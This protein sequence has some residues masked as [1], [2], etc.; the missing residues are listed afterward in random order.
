MILRQTAG[1]GPSTFTYDNLGRLTT[2]TFG[3]SPGARTQS[4]AYNS[5][6]YLQTVTDTL[7]PLSATTTT[8]SGECST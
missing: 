6:G 4:V 2:S 1:L 8:P 3:D 5:Q 7:V